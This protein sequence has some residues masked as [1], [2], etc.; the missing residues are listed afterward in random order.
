MRATPCWWV[1]GFKGWFVDSLKVA[2]A[3]ATAIENWGVEHGDE[4]EKLK[5][6]LNE[7]GYNSHCNLILVIIVPEGRQR[8][9]SNKKVE[10]CSWPLGIDQVIAKWLR[11]LHRFPIVI[12]AEWQKKTVLTTIRRDLLYKY[13]L[14]FLSFACLQ[15]TGYWWLNNGSIGAPWAEISWPPN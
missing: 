13:H 7:I 9:W 10:I 8:L 2:F 3:N 4:R 12:G 1:Q 5:T 15:Q 6:R 14:G 11:Y